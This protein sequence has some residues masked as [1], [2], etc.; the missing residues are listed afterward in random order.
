MIYVGAAFDTMT[1]SAGN[2]LLAIGGE[3]GDYLGPVIADYI[4]DSNGAPLTNSL[5]GRET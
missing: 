2:R 5:I 1:S 3:V 4:Y